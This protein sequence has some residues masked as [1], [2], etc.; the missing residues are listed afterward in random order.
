MCTDIHTLLMPKSPLKLGR[1]ACVISRHWLV[2]RGRAKN[3]AIGRHSHICNFFWILSICPGTV[4]G[5]A[6]VEYLIVI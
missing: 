6:S 4:A 1:A 3:S 2:C 5:R